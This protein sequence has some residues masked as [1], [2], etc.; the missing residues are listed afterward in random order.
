[1]VFTAILLIAA[2]F[3]GYRM[4]ENNYVHNIHGNN[5]TAIQRQSFMTQL[6]KGVKSNW[7]PQ[8]VK[9]EID[10]KYSNFPEKQQKEM[11][12]YLYRSSQN[13]ALYYNSFLYSLRAEMFYYKLQNNKN[14]ISYHSKS[15]T[16]NG[17]F[18]DIA[19]NYEII[20]YLGNNNYQVF[21]DFS[22]IYNNYQLS[23]EMKSFMHKAAQESNSPLFEGCDQKHPFDMMQANNRLSTLLHWSFE[24]KNSEL[25]LDSMSLAKFYYLSILSLNNNNY[26]KDD[27]VTKEYM[28]NL[29]LIIKYNKES[30]NKYM[31]VVNN[32]FINYRKSLKNNNLEINSGIKSTYSTLANTKFGNSVYNSQDDGIAG[33][34]KTLSNNFVKGA[35]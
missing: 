9:K 20:E 25:F 30:N 26:I 28:S 29:D 11:G 13:T 24:H 12:Y 33:A 35:N 10:L 4:Y 27:K 18:M 21:P 32:D 23:N 2:I 14:H 16:V 19:N 22:M 8:E 7:R 1:M 3:V 15:N 31:N 34:S 6:G 17:A 5:L